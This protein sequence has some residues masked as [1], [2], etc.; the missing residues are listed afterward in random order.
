MAHL[1][2]LA[3]V[4]S[5]DATVTQ[6]VAGRPQF[7]FPGSPPKHRPPKPPVLNSGGRYLSRALEL[8]SSAGKWYNYSGLLTGLPFIGYLR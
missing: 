6:K 4:C 7:R 2:L 3:K 1:C 8:A 5:C